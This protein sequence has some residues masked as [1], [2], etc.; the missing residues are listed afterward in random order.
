MDFEREYED[1]LKEKNY[2]EIERQ[3]VFSEILH[4]ANIDEYFSK[5]EDDHNSPDLDYD[6]KDFE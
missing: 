2:I 5:L 1:S 4:F 6:D 3:I